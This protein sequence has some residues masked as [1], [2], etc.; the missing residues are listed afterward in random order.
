MGWPYEFVDLT[1]EEKLLRRQANDRY[2]AIAHFSAL[3]PAVL[4]LLFRLGLAAVKRVLAGREQRYQEVPGSPV[5]KARRSGFLHSYETRWRKLTWWMGDDVVFLNDSWGQRDE[6]VLGIAWTVWLLLL[7]VLGTGKDYLHLT[8]RF[9]AI[10]VS[11]MP[12]QYLLANKALNPFAWVFKSS[13]E[14]VNRYHRVLGRII[15]SL[16]VLHLIFY[17]I[18]F[19]ASSIW[20]KRFFAPIVFAGVVAFT[21]LH[22]LNGTAMREVRRWSYRVFFITHLAAALS[23]PPLIFFHAESA[24]LY[25]IGALLVFTLDIG[26]RKILVVTAPSTLERVPGTDIIRIEATLPASKVSSFAAR[27]G[28]HIY[29]SI[30]PSSRPSQNMLS[31]SGLIYEFLFNPFSVAAVNEKTSTVTLVAR[32][33][34]GPMTAR[35]SSLASGTSSSSSSS[36]DPAPQVSLNIDGPYGATGKTAQDL[37]SLKVDRVLL[38]A[39]GVGATFALPIYQALVNDSNSSAAACPK[40]KLIWAVRSAS[41]AIWASFLGAKSII[42]DDNVELFLTGDMGVGHGSSEREGEQSSGLEMDDLRRQSKKRPDVKRII[43]D[44]FRKDNQGSV[45]VMVCGPAEMAKDVR[46]AVRPWVMRD[47]RV[48][49]HNEAFGW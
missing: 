6:W 26:V 43:D 33:R 12:I 8:K 46:D 20:L 9:G 47:R 3:A 1:S 29:L 34:S 23:V 2:A 30:P 48:H 11:Q 40:V 19:I 36:S 49:W 39:G 42:D 15:Y 14:Q 44:A 5:A 25:V 41:D 37:L 38:F 32:A 10:A 4:C 31:P 18:F 21:G 35:L 45:A 16:L 7:S 27:P 13:H 24:R 22:T 17:N 28:S